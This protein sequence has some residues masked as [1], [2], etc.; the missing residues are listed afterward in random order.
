PLLESL[1]SGNCQLTGTALEGAYVN[2]ARVSATFEGGAEDVT[3]QDAAHYFGVTID[4]TIEKLTNGVDAD[5]PPGVTLKPGTTVTWT[6]MVSSSSNVLL[7]DVAVWDDNGTAANPGD[8]FVVCTVGDLLPGEQ[9]TCHHQ[10]IAAAGPYGNVGTVVANSPLQVEEL[11]SD[12]SHYISFI[13][14]YLPAIIVD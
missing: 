12:R 3:D 13:W 8:D 1:E 11:S 4:L 5:D 2:V 10:G 7:T 14:L 6:Y 9:A